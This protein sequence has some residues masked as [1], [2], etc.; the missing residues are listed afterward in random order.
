M[1]EETDIETRD[2]DNPY[3]KPQRLQWLLG[4]YEKH[5]RRF[6]ASRKSMD[7]K[8][9]WALAT[10]TGFVGF[11]GLAKGES[12]GTVLYTRFTNQVVVIGTS[13]IIMILVA[14]LLAFFYILLLTKVIGVYF[15]Q[16]SNRP[17]HAD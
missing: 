15:P 1:V 3:H 4:K 11:L 2:R 9:I 5:L 14:L 6:E 8:A 16:K 7:Q 10:A 13:Q 17:F 12:I